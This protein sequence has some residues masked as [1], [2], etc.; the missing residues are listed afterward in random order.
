MNIFVIGGVITAIFGLLLAGAVAQIMGTSD[1]SLQQDFEITRNIPT[2]VQGIAVLF[3]VGLVFFI[4]GLSG[5]IYGVLIYN[6]GDDS[7]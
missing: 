5:I 7:K 2:E 4:A 3:P 1:M 6:N